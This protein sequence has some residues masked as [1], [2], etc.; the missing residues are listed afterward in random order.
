MTLAGGVYQATIPAQP[1]GTRV[2]YAVAGERRRRRLRPTA[3]A[4]SPAS[5]RSR[6]CARSMRTASRSTTATPR[7]FRHGHRPAASAPAPTTTTS[8]DA[9]GAIN[10]YR[11]TDTPTPFTSTTPGQVDRSARP[12]RLQRRTPAARHHRV[13]REDDVAVRHHGAGH[14]PGAGAARDHDRA[15]LNTNPEAFEGQLVSIA[16]RQRS[17]SGTFPTDAAAARRV[18]DRHRRHRRTSR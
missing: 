15:A 13:G 1:D 2:D 17:S 18:R 4:T 7:A 11:S 12:H 9:T 10:V 8:Q 16:Q 5:R 3:A 6:R 14:Q